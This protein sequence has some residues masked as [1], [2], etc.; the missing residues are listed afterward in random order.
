MRSWPGVRG[1]KYYLV[2]T[3][4]KWKEFF[5]LLIEQA[6]VACDL[7]C[8]SLS[9]L[10]GQITGFVFSWGVANCYY[11]PVRHTKLVPDPSI[12][13][14]DWDPKKPKWVEEPSDEKQL[15]IEQI[16]DD[17]QA[18]YSDP[19]IVTIWHN[20]K[21]DIHF[22]KMEGFTLTGIVHD[23]RLMH[24]L[25]DENTSAALK[26]IA[27]ALIDC[28]ANK[29]ERAIDEWRAKFAREHKIPKKDVHYGLIP[30]ELMVPYAAS[31]GHYTL[32]IYKDHL[33]QIANDPS[34]LTLYAQVEAKLLWTL[35]D[36]EHDGV[37]INRDYLA[38]AGPEMKKE[39][40][41][42][43]VVVRDK[44][45]S[46]TININSNVQVIPLLQKK[47]VH[48]WK[49]TKTGRPSLDAEVLEN[50]AT[51]HDVCRDLMNY[52]KLDKKLGTYVNSIL[53]KTSVDQ[54]L[55]CDYNQNVST[56]RLSGKKPNLMNIPRAD[57]SI[58]RSFVA[59]QRFECMHCDFTD[60][61]CTAPRSCPE[62]GSQQFTVDDGY[63]LCFIDLSQ[64]EVRLT[65]HFSQD[66][67][68]L[69]V[70]NHTGEDV[71][72]RT[73]CEMFGYRYKEAV[74]ILS[75]KNHS[76]YDE[77][78][79]RR[80]IAKMINF[81]I[82]YGGGAK[83]LS[84]KISTPEEPYTEATCK[85]FIRMYFDRYK[86]VQK[87]INRAKLQCRA[88]LGIQN[89]F[90]RWRRLP[91][92]KD[93]ERRMLIRSEKWKI[94]RAQRQ[95]VNYLIQG[96]AADLFKIALVRVYDLLKDK[97]TRLVMPI[98]DEI[99]LYYHKSEMAL[100]PQIKH[101]MEDFD[102]SVP[103]IAEVAYSTTSWA[104]KQEL[105]AA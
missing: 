15:R 69:E 13:Q 79:K 24:N 85:Q 14:E 75:D 83:S 95:G 35:L 68:L 22:L 51:K 84:A 87:W 33:P 61:Y 58:R 42:L 55:H 25:I 31:D 52:R 12:P 20:G 93:A 23:T 98:H 2:D 59:P 49:K 40:D 94:E 88:Q 43:G 30:L 10:T 44:L 66:P 18:F 97:K 63:F 50:L 53:E 21:F 92:L 17:L 73:C 76:K 8:N 4:P 105:K 72:L 32:M 1:G 81:L 91:E 78:K 16:W 28:D 71:H 96:T 19:D 104:D 82:I 62:C 37:V 102:F 7:E 77:V 54:K 100:L 6:A 70:Y 26:D 86:G 103:I 48:F 29:W 60:D 11:V 64:I 101:E 67:I 90:G 89:Y 27:V 39:M 47:G 34:L 3:L 41:R 5:K 36:M 56:G 74:V 45:G 80:Q 9:Y 65:A 99:V 46:E 57:V 38:E